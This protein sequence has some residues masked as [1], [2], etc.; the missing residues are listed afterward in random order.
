MKV[1]GICGSPR[2]GGNAD[3]LLDK[4]LEG[5]GAAGAE[6]EKISISDLNIS[7]IQESEYEKV[8]EEGFSVVADDMSMIFK[9]IREADVLIVASPI[10]FGS[11]ST[12][13]KLMIDRFQCVWLSK[14]IHN[15]DLYPDRIAGGFICVEATDR[16][17]FFE[18]AKSIIRH[19]FA[20]I[21]TEYTEELFCS[22]CDKKESVLDHS[23]YL[24]KAFELGKNLVSVKG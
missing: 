2:K 24:E 1:L 23:E 12:Q 17:D 19:F 7:P 3:T 6:T 10:F 22:G 15:K 16:E 13:T 4:A 14:F 21:N 8:N 9:K 20:I 5:A 11:L 18:N